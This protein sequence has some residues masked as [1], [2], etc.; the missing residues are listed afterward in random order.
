MGGLQ[1]GTAINTKA[2][3]DQ[4]SQFD[5]YDGGGLDIACNV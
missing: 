5:F 1:F 4:S 2:V 3:I